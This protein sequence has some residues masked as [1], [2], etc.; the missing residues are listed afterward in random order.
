MGEPE[1]YS[2]HNFGKFLME[3]LELALNEDDFV[4]KVIMGV[5]DELSSISREYEDEILRSYYTV[6]K[7]YFEM[8]IL[9]IDVT[10]TE[11]GE[12]EAHH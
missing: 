8:V 1:I 12:S 9:D 3:M 4:N 11:D 5:T 10:F 6:Y 7:N 2:G